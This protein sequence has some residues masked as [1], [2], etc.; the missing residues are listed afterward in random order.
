MT[1]EK[2]HLTYALP[3]KKRVTC[4]SD[5]DRNARI[6]PTV[7][8]PHLNGVVLHADAQ[9]DENC[10]I[11]QQVTL[12]QTAETGA[13]HVH[14][15]AYIGA[16]AKVLGD[17]SIGKNARIGANAVV[18]ESVPDNATAVGVPARVTKVRN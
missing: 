11:M 3:L 1:Y 15:G 14:A 2:E 10:M 4:H 16:G 6:H 12:G 7:R 9:V 5:I 8:F 13:P 17:I 18:L